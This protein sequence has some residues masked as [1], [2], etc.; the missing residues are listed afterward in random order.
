MTRTFVVTAVILNVNDKFSA[1]SPKSKLPDVYSYAMNHYVCLSLTNRKSSI[2]LLAFYS[3]RTAL[4]TYIP[5]VS[6]RDLW[7]VMAFP[8]Y[9]S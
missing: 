9:D 5:Q 3:P 4:R 1:H 2:H 7:T 8:Q 6:T